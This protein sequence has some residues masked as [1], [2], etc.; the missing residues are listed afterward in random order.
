MARAVLA[1]RWHG[2]FGRR[3]IA[4]LFGLFTF[5]FTLASFLAPPFS[6]LDT[7]PSLA[8]VLLG[9]SVLMGDAVLALA[10][11]VTGVAGV[12]LTAFLGNLAAR[13]VGELV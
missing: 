4:P 7:L 5:V 3:L 6:G 2:L 13:A 1:S 9:V 11:L 10:G 12:A 8:V